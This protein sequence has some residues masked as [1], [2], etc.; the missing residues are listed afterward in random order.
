[1]MK[2]NPVH[3][4][5]TSFFIL[6]GIGELIA[7]RFLGV[8]HYVNALASF[9]AA[10][11]LRLPDLFARIDFMQVPPAV[12]LFFTIYIFLSIFFG[13]IL[14]FYELFPHWDTFLHFLSGILFS[15]VGLILFFSI[16]DKE[17]ARQIRP[18]VAVLFALFFSAT[19]GLVWE[20]YEFTI[21]SL[22]GMNMQRW[23]SN[24]SVAEWLALHNQSNRS[25]PGLIDTMWDLV[26]ATLGS[27]VSIPLLGYVIRKSRSGSGELESPVES[28]S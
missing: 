20:I 28:S 13:S 1:M 21:D 18:V 25:N 12:H 27:L 6:W 15:L 2:R 16:Q 17:F 23:Q 10:G 8:S 26:A 11:L 14:G 24:L 19:C 7:G 5:A 4:V 3:L 22:A 9:V